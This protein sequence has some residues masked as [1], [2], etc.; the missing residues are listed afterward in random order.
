[1][2]LDPHYIEW[3][4]LGARWLHM[5]VGIAWI[6]A[7]FYFNWLENHL[8]RRSGLREGIAG[9]LWAVHG[10]GFYFLEKYQV[11]PPQLPPKLHWFKWE[12][13][14]TWLSGMI[15]LVIVYYVGA[16]SYL[17]DATVSNIGVG[18]AICVSFFSL[19][20]CWFV[21]DGLCRSPLVERGRLFFSL[22]F[23]LIS[24]YA[25]A[26]CQLFSGRAAFVHVG[27]MIGTLMVGN[28]FFV[29][30]P[31]QRKWVNA[32]LAGQPLDPMLGK[33]ALKRSRH[34]N[35]LTLPVLFAMISN[36]FPFTFGHVQSWL[37]MAGML[38]AGIAIRHYF[39][40]RHL[41]GKHAWALVVGLGVLVVLVVYTRPARTV[42]VR[43]QSGS[44]P[45]TETKAIAIIER[46]C[47]PCHAKQPTD[48]VFTSPPNGMVFD[49][50]SDVRRN[51]VKI[52]ERAVDTTS[53]P[54]ANKTMM[55]D[56]ER[57]QLGDWLRSL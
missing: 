3:L 35:Y 26:V 57:R 46:R 12:A 47:T 10:G 11:A 2:V 37:I 40:I 4:H 28:V 48:D 1:M 39:N 25:Y 6:G 34:N 19:I 36:H 7:S 38:L 55:T 41:P 56:E 15:L 49:T 45:I 23:V 9:D 54:L 30:I 27:A 29:I 31:H 16:K 52:I 51:A 18:T 32:A 14:T 22:G 42:A 43:S 24:L 21:Y 13:Y 17:L 33:K 50:P 53:M 44:L 8:D 20:A 5:I